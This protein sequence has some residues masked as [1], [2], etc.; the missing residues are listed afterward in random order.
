M[1]LKTEFFDLIKEKRERAP[2]KTVV[3]IINLR[4]GAIRVASMSTVG[5]CG[6]LVIIIRFDD[7]FDDIFF[8]ILFI[9]QS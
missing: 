4:S 6:E 5:I 3:D 8:V 7:L 9:C 1:I 2:V